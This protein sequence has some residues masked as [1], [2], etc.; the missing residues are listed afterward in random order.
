MVN[1]SAYAT[2]AELKGMGEVFNG[3]KNRIL[4]CRVPDC[5]GFIRKIAQVSLNY[6]FYSP[7]V[8]GQQKCGCQVA[9]H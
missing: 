6:Y 4:P 2:Y 3:Q 9:K 5:G 1:N 8:L 7:Y